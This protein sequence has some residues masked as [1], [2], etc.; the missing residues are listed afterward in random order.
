MDVNLFLIFSGVF[1]SNSSS[2]TLAEMMILNIPFSANL[3]YLSVKMMTDNQ[4][5][6]KQV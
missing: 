4:Y 6:K 1:L 2:L 5:H 3:F